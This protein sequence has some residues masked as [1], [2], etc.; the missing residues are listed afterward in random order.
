MWKVKFCGLDDACQQGNPDNLQNVLFPQKDSLYFNVSYHMM[1]Q[2]N[3]DFQ[4][5]LNIERLEE[6]FLNDFVGLY[7]HFFSKYE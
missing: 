6:N 2:I 4:H 3:P 7:R 1:R 5:E